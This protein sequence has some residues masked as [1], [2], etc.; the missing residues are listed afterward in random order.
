[1]LIF[2]KLDESKI[3]IKGEMKMDFVMIL[4]IGGYLG[5][6]W[7]FWRGFGRTNFQPNWGNKLK[8]SLLWPFLVISSK[9][10]RQ[11]FQKAIKGS[12]RS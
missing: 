5:G 6:I 2:A 9:S 10:Y 3:T 8:L 1:M 12:N 7:R 4:L 11:N